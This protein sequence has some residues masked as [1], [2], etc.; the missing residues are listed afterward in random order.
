[1]QFQLHLN[2]TSR[3]L[4]APYMSTQTLRSTCWR[5]VHALLV[6]FFNAFIQSKALHKIYIGKRTYLQEIPDLDSVVARA[7]GQHGPMRVEGHTRHPIPMT[8]AAHEEVAVRHGPDLPRLVVAHCG[9]YRL[10]DGTHRP[11]GGWVG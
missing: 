10:R 1:M 5:Y 2:W 3:V 4:N 11:A 7:G 6:G 8:L 9:N